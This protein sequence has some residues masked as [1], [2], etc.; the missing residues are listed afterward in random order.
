MLT[1]KIYGRIIGYLSKDNKHIHFE[2][3]PGFQQSGFEVSPFIFPVSSIR[4]QKR[5]SNDTFKGLP[6]F[7]A[8]ALP[9]NF[10][11][12]VIDSYFAK[13]GQSKSDVSVLDRLSYVGSKAIG[14]LEFEPYLASKEGYQAPLEVNKLVQ[15]ARSAIKGDIESVS[16][17]LISIGSSAGGARPKALIG[18]TSDFKN[19]IAG[20]YDL[21]EGFEHYLIKF[22]GVDKESVECD[23]QG[24]SNIE[25]AYFL[26]ARDSGIDISD[27]FLLGEGEREHFV[28]KRFDRQGNQ[29]IHVQT[30]CAMSGIDFNEFQ[31][32]SYSDYFSAVINLGL[33]VSSQEDAFRRMVFNVLGVNRDDHTKNFSFLLSSDGT[34]SLAPAYDITHAYNEV[35]PNAWTREHNLLING[36]G[37]DISRDD[38]ILESSLLSL[39]K[40]VKNKVIDQVLLSVRKWS[41]FAKL[42]RVGQLKV[43]AIRSR[44]EMAQAHL[45]ACSTGLEP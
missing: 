39:N 28:T 10:G 45:E 25:Y 43:D 36:K 6:E 15:D 14:A 5:I 3:D 33:P 1:V 16:Q 11:N 38:L 24:Y 44:I 26:M 31:S 41:E 8:D 37:L 42:A 18:A 21:P 35:N 27:S 34:W 2:Y 4:S 17:E 13:K 19:I 23:P 22:D 20:Q 30:L 40:S 32:G 12:R 7:I 29:K 9:D